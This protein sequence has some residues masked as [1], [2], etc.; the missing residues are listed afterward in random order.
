MLSMTRAAVP[1]R[2]MAIASLTLSSG[3]VW[4]E[5]KFLFDVWNQKGAGDFSIGR[6]QL[7][8]ISLC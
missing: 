2:C 7:G 3:K 6:G 8:F 4:K 1:E 5:M